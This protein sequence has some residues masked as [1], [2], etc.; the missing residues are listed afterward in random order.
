MVPRIRRS[1]CSARKQ[2]LARLRFA[3]ANVSRPLDMP[4]QPGLPA[5]CILSSH[6]AFLNITSRG[7]QAVWASL[8][9]RLVPGSDNCVETSCDCRYGVMSQ[10]VLTGNVLKI[11]ESA[12]V[13]LERVDKVQ[14][15]AGRDDMCDQSSKSCSFSLVFYCKCCQ[16][17]EEGILQ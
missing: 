1:H 14:L 4:F 16:L 15:Q 13:L 8:R 10:C 12:S 3:T 11:K 7:G 2:S 6:D 9:P 5:P 17:V